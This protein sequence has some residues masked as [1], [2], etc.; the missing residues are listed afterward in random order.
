MSSKPEKLTQD[1]P[2]FTPGKW[3]VYPE[4]DKCEYEVWDSGDNYLKDNRQ[5]VANL[6]GAAPQLYEALEALIAETKRC[7]T[8][9][10]MG[11]GSDEDVIQKAEAALKSARGGK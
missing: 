5:D 1:K 4:K 2:G 8:P 6:L 10:L 3:R 9:G 7:D 11:V